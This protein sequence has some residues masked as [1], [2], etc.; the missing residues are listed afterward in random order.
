MTLTDIIAKI[1]LFAKRAIVNDNSSNTAVSINQTGSGI[2]LS[3]ASTA[4]TGLSV[5][6]V[7]GTSVLVE[8]TNPVAGKGGKLEI[9]HPT[10]G[11]FVFDGGTD[12]LFV[13]TNTTATGTTGFNAAKTFFNGGNVGIGIANPTFKLEVEGNIKAGRTDTVN[14]GGQIQLSRAIDNLSAWAIDVFGNTV[15]PSFRIINITTNTEHLRIEQNGNVGIGVVPVRKLHVNGLVRLQ[16]LQTYANN[17]A[18]I[19]GGLV[20]D[21]VYKTVTGELR[22]VI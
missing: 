12:G 4:G 13:F 17:A 8:N 5:K 21:D 15:T 2:G 11:D 19:T 9:F 20:A 10:N 18:A 7:A 6:S 22:I 16:G 3:V 1:T 14:E